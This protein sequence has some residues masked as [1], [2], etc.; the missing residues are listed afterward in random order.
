MQETSH[1]DAIH[2]L[3]TADRQSLTAELSDV[4]TEM[5]SVQREL[6]SAKEQHAM[7]LQCVKQQADAMQ[8]QANKHSKQ[9]ELFINDFHIKGK[10]K[11]M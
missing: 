7:E 9:Y 1:R 5:E 4:R 6:L 2:L 11:G 3:I 10:E 8:I